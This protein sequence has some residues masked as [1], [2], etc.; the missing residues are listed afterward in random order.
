MITNSFLLNLNHPMKYLP[1]SIN[2]QLSED[3]TELEGPGY[4]DKRSTWQTFVD[5]FNL[6]ARKKGTNN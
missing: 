2:T 3:G 6:A 1:R 4:E 5:P